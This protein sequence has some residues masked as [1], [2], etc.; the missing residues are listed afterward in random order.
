M[1]LLSDLRFFA[2]FHREVQNPLGF[3]GGLP[4]LVTGELRGGGAALVAAGG[5][6]KFLQWDANVANF[7]VAEGSVCV[8]CDLKNQVALLQGGLVDSKPHNV[9]PAGIGAVVLVQVRPL[10]V[11]VICGDPCDC[12]GLGFGQN[13]RVVQITGRD[14]R[15]FYTPRLHRT[16]MNS[17]ERKKTNEFA[18]WNW[19][20]NPKET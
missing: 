13:A 11:S 10:P 2:Q 15:Y 19:G 9:V 4:D 14:Q 7:F 17:V 20:R 16:T 12:V 1:Q 6:Q 18:G 3:S 5:L 8:Y